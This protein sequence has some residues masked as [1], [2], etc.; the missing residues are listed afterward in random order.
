[1]LSFYNIKN[2][3]YFAGSFLSMVVIIIWGFISIKN[4][5]FLLDL[6]CLCSGGAGLKIK[7]LSLE[8]GNTFLTSKTSC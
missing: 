4:P 8:I 5:G 6:F 3:V 7:W 2:P 1:M